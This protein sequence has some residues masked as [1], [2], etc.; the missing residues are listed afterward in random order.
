MNWEEPYDRSAL[1]GNLSDFDQSVTLHKV[2]ETRCERF[3][4]RLVREHHYL[5]YENQFGGRVKYLATLGQKLVG[6]V[7]F[8]AGAYQLGP[9]DQFIGWDTGTTGFP[10]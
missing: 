3:W 1:E 9:R 7:S 5:G 4:D 8:C 6:A 10:G 2:D